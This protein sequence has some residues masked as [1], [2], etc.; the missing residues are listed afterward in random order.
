MED[1]GSSVGDEASSKASG[2]VAGAGSGFASDYRRGK[3]YK[4]LVK[5]LTSNKAQAS[6]QRCGSVLG[7]CCRCGGLAGADAAARGAGSPAA[8]ARSTDC[9]AGSLLHPLACR[10]TASH[11]FPPSALRSFWRRALAILAML[12]AVHIACYVAAVV[13]VGLQKNYVSDMDQSGDGVDNSHRIMVAARTI[14]DKYFPATAASRPWS[15][16]TLDTWVERLGEKATEVKESH[17]GVYLGFSSLRRLDN[18]GARAPP[19]ARPPARPLARR[20][21]ASRAA[22]AHPCLRNSDRR[23]PPP[24]APLQTACC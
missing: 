8:F 12:L 18:R 1:N 7:L 14:A 6:I 5:M 2:S 10:L 9:A 11:H 3:R 20:P 15:A 4:K 23:I 17:Y 13:M 22:A 19:P 24:R 16:D 21:R